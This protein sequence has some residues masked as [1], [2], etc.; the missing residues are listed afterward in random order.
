M[1]TLQQRLESA[2]EGSYTK[3]LF[4]DAALLKSKLVEEAIELSQATTKEHVAEEAADLL[5]VD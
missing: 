4:N 5:Y 3:R 2:P 1:N